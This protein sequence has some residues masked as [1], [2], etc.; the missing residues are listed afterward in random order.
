MKMASGFF[1][2]GNYSIR[3]LAASCSS[4]PESATSPG[5]SG[6]L[7]GPCLP[8]LEND[9]VDTWLARSGHK[10]R[11]RH[12]AH[13]LE[14]NLAWVGVAFLFTIA[15]GFVAHYWGLPWARTLYRLVFEPSSLPASRQQSLRRRFQGLV[16][17][18][19]EGFSYK[20]RGSA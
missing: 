3:K 10:D 7:T 6:F 18:D 11:H 14:S 4:D 19:R 15:S 8:T 2:M 16:P 9:Q 5:R 20:L 12:W 1:R 13:I 17:A